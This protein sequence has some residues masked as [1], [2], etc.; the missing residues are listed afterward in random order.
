MAQSPSQGV[1]SIT[2]QSSISSPVVL[3]E[4]FLLLPRKFQHKTLKYYPTSSDWFCRY[5][6]PDT[7]LILKEFYQYPKVFNKYKLLGERWELHWE[8]QCKLV[9]EV[10]WCYCRGAHIQAPPPPKP[11]HRWLT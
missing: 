9:E 2:Y 6:S 4:K 8:P 11:K 1:Y 7:G 3:D 5:R 10:L